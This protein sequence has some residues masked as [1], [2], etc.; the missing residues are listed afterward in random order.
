LGKKGEESK[1]YFVKLVFLKK[2]TKK[3]DKIK[4][5]SFCKERSVSQAIL[6]VFAKKKKEK[7]EKKKS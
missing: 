2:K 6:G 1:F 4:R 7:K 5:E 3:V